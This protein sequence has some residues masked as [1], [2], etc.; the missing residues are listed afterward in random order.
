MTKLH[1]LHTPEMVAQAVKA[2]GEYFD[3]ARRT[4][5]S[6]AIALELIAAAIRN[7]GLTIKIKDHCSTPRADYALAMR[8]SEMVGMLGLKHIYVRSMGGFTLRFGEPT[9]KP[10]V[11]HVTGHVF[12]AAATNKD[13]VPT[14]DDFLKE[15]TRRSSEFWLSLGEWERERAYRQPSKFRV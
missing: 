8:I 2:T 3:P 14:M 12:A 6:T 5:R 15:H 10:T 11:A 4:G 9:Q 13:T 7:P 1:P